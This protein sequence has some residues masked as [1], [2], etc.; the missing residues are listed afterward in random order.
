VEP[1]TDLP[2]WLPPGGEHDAFHRSDVSKVI[3]AGLRCRPVA[4]TV[5]DTWSWLRSIGGQAPMRPDRPPVGLAPA[6]EAKLL[7]E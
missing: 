7:K 5:E 2:I 1:W 3:A 4:E 6:V